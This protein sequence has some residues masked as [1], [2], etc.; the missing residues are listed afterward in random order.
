[1]QPKGRLLR[2]IIFWVL[3]AA[4]FF[5]G[6]WF[7]RFLY[8]LHYADTIKIEADRN[9]LDPMLVQAVVRVESRFNPSAKSSK[10]AIGLMQLMPE[11]ADWIAEKKGE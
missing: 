5:G 2:W 3:V 9:G 6:K 10:G 8:P 1:M 11:T 4:G 7:M